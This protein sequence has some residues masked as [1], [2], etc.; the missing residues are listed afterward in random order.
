[1]YRW[2]SQGKIL[3][4]KLQRVGG[5]STLGRTEVR[6]AL[7]KGLVGGPMRCPYAQ[8]GKAIWGLG[9]CLSISNGSTGRRPWEVEGTVGRQRV[10]IECVFLILPRK[11]WN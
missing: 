5:G 8:R 3:L 4:R 2:G 6:T 9:Q 10:L 7:E 1:M 11:L